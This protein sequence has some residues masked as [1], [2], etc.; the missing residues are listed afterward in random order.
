MRFIIFLKALTFI[1]IKIKFFK[2]QTWI[3][4]VVVIFFFQIK[5]YLPNLKWLFCFVFDYKIY[6]WTLMS[7]EVNFFLNVCLGLIK[8]NE[9]D[10]LNDHH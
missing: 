2:F 3:F 8:L 5:I 9:N 1:H 7:I 10:W 4:V 6:A